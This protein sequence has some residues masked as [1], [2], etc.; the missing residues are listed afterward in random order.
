MVHQVTLAVLISGW[1][2][3]LHAM[4]KP[5]GQ[6]SVMYAL[7]HGSLFVTSFVFLMGLLFKVNS[8][9][10]ESTVYAALAGIMLLLCTG[11]IVTWIL[12][13]LR[14]IC[15]HLPGLTGKAATATVPP[16][17]VR[18][19]GTN[20]GSVLRRAPARG[21]GRGRGRGRVCGNSGAVALPESTGTDILNHG[22]SLHE[23]VAVDQVDDTLRRWRR[24]STGINCDEAS[25]GSARSGLVL[26]SESRRIAELSEA[27]HEPSVCSVSLPS[28]G[29]CL[30]SRSHLGAESAC[31]ETASRCHGYLSVPELASLHTEATARSVQVTESLTD[32]SNGNRSGNVGG[33]V[34]DSDTDNM[35]A[36]VSPNDTDCP[37]QEAPTGTWPAATLP[38]R[39]LEAA[40]FDQDISSACARDVVSGLELEPDED[41]AKPFA[42]S[43]AMLKQSQPLSR[44]PRQESEPHSAQLAPSRAN[45]RRLQ[46]TLAAAAT[47]R[48]KLW[49]V[50]RGLSR[51]FTDVLGK[52]VTQ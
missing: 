34:G 51:R 14:Q 13:I 46:R 33:I 36:A 23:V 42:L 38:A 39:T 24:R 50:A 37:G 28:S 12:I 48:V 19:S 8:V 15:Q 31:K 49:L 20:T 45:C 6:G 21:R 7:Q 1:A 52:G 3:V 9:S 5:W 47:F 27:I 16:K 4:Y 32:C 41:R 25:A 30:S 2:H 26:T 11:F 43:L 44:L 22:T 35:M 17:P 18:D 40:P 10:P 29:P